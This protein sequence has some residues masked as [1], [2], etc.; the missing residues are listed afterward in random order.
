MELLILGL[1]LL[2]LLVTIV[3]IPI[4]IAK[5]R[6]VSGS[7]LT[8]VAILAWLGIFIGITWII[9]LVLALIYH[10]KEWVDKEKGNTNLDLV[11]LEKIHDL[12]EKG[13]LSEAEYKRE[14][15]RLLGKEEEPQVNNLDQLEKLN[16]LYKKGVL[17]EAEFNEQKKA[18]LK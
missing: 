17:T 6:G 9:A 1:V 2:L 14:R 4:I 13:I 3:R 10:P 12:K 18:L 8:T 16:N 5:A 7:E 11:S 15:Q